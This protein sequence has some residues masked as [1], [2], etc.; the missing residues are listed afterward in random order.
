MKFKRVTIREWER[1]MFAD[2]F[3]FHTKMSTRKGGS[4][5]KVRQQT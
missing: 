3:H 2:E 5:E 4:E 1:V